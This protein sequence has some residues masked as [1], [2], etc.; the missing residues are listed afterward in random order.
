VSG[1]SVSGNSTAPHYFA[2]VPGRYLG[3]AEDYAA[4]VAL[5]AVRRGWRVTVG[6]AH[7]AC[8][9]AISERVPDA[10]ILLSREMTLP[11][12]LG[13]EAVAATIPLTVRAQGHRRQLVRAA[14]SVV[15]AVLPWHWWS[16]AFLWST[17]HE[18][19]PCLVTFQLVPPERPPPS[20]YRRLFSELVDRGARLCAI[21]NNNRQLLSGYYGLPIEQ[22]ECIPNRPRSLQAKLLSQEQRSEVRRGLGVTETE[23]VILTV[24]ALIHQKGHDTLIAGVPDI[25]RAFPSARFL[26]AGT[27][28]LDR[29][30]KRQAQRLNVREFIRFLG[31]RSD[32]DALLGAADLF[33]FPTRFEGESFALMEAAA[34]GLPIVAS[35]AS[36]IP[37]TFRDGEDALLFAVDDVGDMVSKVLSVLRDPGAGK[38]RSASA[39]QRVQAY[40]EKQMLDA[41]FGLLE[42]VITTGGERCS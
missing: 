34:A 6:C 12:R 36:G 24:G 8:L 11:G 17:R 10:H 41:T 26:L 23:I 29:K 5:E 1:I 35:R 33:L 16:E 22:I 31:R 9:E 13:R 38:E 42:A 7:Q 39:M 14:P 32:I 25:V 4:R 37:E 15:H 28:P 30:L 2:W 40:P 3:G 21:S 20:R 18:R 19:L 27:G